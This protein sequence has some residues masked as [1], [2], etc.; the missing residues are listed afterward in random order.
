MDLQWFDSFLVT[1]KD[2]SKYVELRVH[3]NAMNG[4]FFRYDQF[5]QLDI[6]ISGKGIRRGSQQLFTANGINVGV[7]SHMMSLPNPRHTPLLEFV[8]V[9]SKTI[10]FMVHASHASAE[11]PDDFDQQLK[12]MH[13]DWINLDMADPRTFLFTGILPQIWGIQPR[14][15]EVEAML[16]A[17]SKKQGAICSLLSPEGPS[18]AHG[19][20]VAFEACSRAVCHCQIAEPDAER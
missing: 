15:V 20:P 10:S 18:G 19:T 1:G 5:R 13:L 6:K 12:Y 16:I 9:E 8:V 17:P 14:T 3:Q 4:S 2:G 11:F 7:G